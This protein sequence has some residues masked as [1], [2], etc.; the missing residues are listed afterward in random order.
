MRKQIKEF[1]HDRSS[2]VIPFLYDTVVPF[3]RNKATAQVQQGQEG[4]PPVGPGRDREIVG[5]QQRRECIVGISAL[6]PRDLV[7]LGVKAHQRG[8]VYY[9]IPSWFQMK[10][11]RI[12]ESRFR[13]DMFKHVEKQDNI[14]KLAQIGAS[15]LN[16]IAKNTASIRNVFLKGIAVQVE[17]IHVDSQ[18]FLELTL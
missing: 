4:Q 3:T 2:G 1:V 8:S 10:Q 17:T 12:Q 13:F 16:V 7:I 18:G 6:V 14:I 5:A 9:Q 11:N 15:V